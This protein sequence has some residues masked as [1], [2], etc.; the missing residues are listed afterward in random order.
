VPGSQKQG[1]IL[2]GMWI[3]KKEKII[4]KTEVVCNGKS[5]LK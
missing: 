1:V 4:T 5:Y 2:M 3:I